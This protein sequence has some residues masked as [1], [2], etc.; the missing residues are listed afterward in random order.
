MLRR[1]WGISLLIIL[2]FSHLEHRSHPNS[3]SPHLSSQQPPLPLASYCPDPNMHWNECRKTQKILLLC[4]CDCS[5]L[6]FTGHLLLEW[7]LW[8]S[9]PLLLWAAAVLSLELKIRAPCPCSASFALGEEV[10]WVGGEKEG[11][12]KNHRSKQLEAETKLHAFHTRADSGLWL[13]LALVV[14]LWIVPSLTLS[15]RL[16]VTSHTELAYIPA[17]KLSTGIFTKTLW[18]FY[19]LQRWSLKCYSK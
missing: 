19:V 1:G 6:S 9:T 3:P 7:H 18:V 4:K 2:L 17:P 13:Q 8:V 16:L 11:Q 12:T 15:L 5:A 14:T 10:T